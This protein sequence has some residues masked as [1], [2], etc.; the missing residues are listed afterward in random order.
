MKALLALLLLTL[1]SATLANTI[2]VH[3]MKVVPKQVRS[4]SNDLYADV[5]AD[6]E[7]IQRFL[8]LGQSKLQLSD[9]E[10]AYDEAKSN[11]TPRKTHANGSESIA[12]L[13]HGCNC[14]FTDKKGTIYF[15]R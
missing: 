6:K 7:L 4:F 10:L 15:W 5:V 12:F 11:S 13:L 9:E 3:P 2:V 1:C 14:V 8:T